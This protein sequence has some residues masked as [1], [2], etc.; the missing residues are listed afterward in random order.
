MVKQY[1]P[2]AFI[3]CLLNLVKLRHFTPDEVIEIMKK[4]SSQQETELIP[5]MKEYLEA[6]LSGENWFISNYFSL[7]CEFIFNLFLL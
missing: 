3:E 2:D 4:E 7:L 1:R 6:L 5:L